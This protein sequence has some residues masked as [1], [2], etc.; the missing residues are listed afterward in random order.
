V[1]IG[2]Q[3]EQLAMRTHERAA[4][5]RDL[6]LPVVIRFRRHAKR[7]DD[8][9]VPPD[10][11]GRHELLPLLALQHRE[12]THGILDPLES[13]AEVGCER[14]YRRED[15]LVTRRHRL[16]APARVRDVDARCVR[17]LAQDGHLLVPCLFTRST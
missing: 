15:R 7:H 3:I 8:R 2:G 17:E 10:H 6:D 4:L 14:A 12:S 1:R 11:H 13:D 16:V 5:G 9:S